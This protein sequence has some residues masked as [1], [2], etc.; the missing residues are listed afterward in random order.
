MMKSWVAG[1]LVWMRDCP[2][3]TPEPRI[4]SWPWWRAASLDEVIQATGSRTAPRLLLASAF[5][6]FIVAGGIDWLAIA[7][8]LT[9]GSAAF[10]SIVWRV[11][12][13]AF[14]FPYIRP[15]PFL[16]YWLWVFFSPPGR[17]SGALE[18]S[19][20]VAVLSPFVFALIW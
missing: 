20:W 14:V 4:G 3:S 2:V 17:R 10:L 18:W 12:W 13:W 11:G 7:S 9:L 16:G 6:S 5:W 1:S 19:A 15:V 8:F